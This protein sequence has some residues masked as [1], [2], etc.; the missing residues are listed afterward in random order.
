MRFMVFMIPSRTD[1]LEGAMP[2]NEAIAAMTKFN[3]DLAKA[4]ILI[5]GDGLAP[6]AKGARV[7]FATGKG[8]LAGGPPTEARE[9]IGGYWV[10]QTKTKEEAIAW[11]R[12]CPAVQKDQVIEL[13][14]I[15]EME[16]FA[17]S[18]EVDDAY[19][20]REIGPHR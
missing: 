20:V 14:K 13:R 2:S 1:Y 18:K 19:K 9:I 8:E 6:P 12:R 11:A 7:E 16:D 3:E 5:A 10:W 15:F 17:P 4:G